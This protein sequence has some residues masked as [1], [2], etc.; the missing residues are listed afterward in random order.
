MA[1]DW[2]GWLDALGVRHVMDSRSLDFADEII[3]RDPTRRLKLP[4]FSYEKSALV[5]FRDLMLFLEVAKAT[6]PRRT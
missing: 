5:P 4:K 1:R 6:S 2:P 3:E